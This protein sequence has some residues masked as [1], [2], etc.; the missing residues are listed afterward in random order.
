MPKFIKCNKNELSL[1]YDNKLWVLIRLF[2]N[3]NDYWI[4]LENENNIYSSIIN[5]LSKEIVLCN[6]INDKYIYYPFFINIF[7]RY[8]KIES[9]FISVEF[10]SKNIYIERLCLFNI[11]EYN[12]QI[13]YSTNDLQ[14]IIKLKEGILD[15]IIISDIKIEKKSWFIFIN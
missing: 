4:K 14:I 3:K 13:I 15:K 1:P 8:T 5:L 6:K 7:K 2:N 10:L 9:V 11:P 12:N